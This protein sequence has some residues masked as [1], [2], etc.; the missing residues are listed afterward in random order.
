MSSLTI[1]ITINN[2]N[3]LLSAHVTSTGD[4]PD[5]IFMYENSGTSTLGDYQGVCTLSEYKSMQTFS[6][7]PLPAFGNRFVKTNSLLMSFPLSTDAASI[8]AKVIADVKSFK[9]AYTAAA[10]TTDVVSL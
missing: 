4:M 8:K 7:T 2:G 5:D 1:N 10:T 9:A 6:G 3:Y